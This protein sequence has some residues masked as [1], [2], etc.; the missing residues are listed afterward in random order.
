MPA[1]LVCSVGVSRKN[2]VLC[3]YYLLT[4]TAGQ[5][6]RMLA[7]AAN[8]R[9]ISIAILDKEGS[10][11]KQ[12]NLNERNVNGSF[13]NPEDIRRFARHCDILTVEIEHVDTQVLEQ[14]EK[15]S[16]AQGKTIEIQPSWESLRVIQ[17][18]YLQA[19]RLIENNVEV[20]SSIPIESASEAELKRAAEKL[21]FP[22]MLK[23]R[24]GK[25]NFSWFLRGMTESP[26]EPTMARVILRSNR[27]LISVLPCKRCKGDHFLFKDGLISPKNWLSW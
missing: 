10:P 18:K 20:A 8:R 3:R 23:A 12:I 9:N 4:W 16:K 21:G 2:Q 24:T 17:D 26:Q 5:L 27:N 19:E 25:A 11:A 15:E 22:F 1:L 6:G 14:I 7:E 13:S